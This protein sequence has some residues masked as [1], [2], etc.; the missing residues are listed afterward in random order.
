MA[1]KEVEA[2][3]VEMTAKCGKRIILGSVYKSP[4]TN[5]DK[6]KIH[7]EEICNKIK[8]EKQKKELVIGMDHNMDL[9]K[10]HE[11]RHTQ[12]F[13]DTLLNNDLIPTITRPTRITKTSATLI[14]N[15]FIS[16]MLQQSFDSMILIE[17]ISDHLPSLVLMKQTKLRNKDPLQFKSRKL[18]ADKIKC[19]KDD[20]K[21]KDWNGILRSDNVNTNFENFCNELDTTMEKFAL[22][23]EVRISWKRKH[24]E[25]WMSK[26]IERVAQRC[27][28]LY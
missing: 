5:D 11:H 13:L 12:Q 28:N 15:V 14:D 24:I 21:K 17:E 25:P 2:T 3:Y 26:S 10:S 19:L 4:N 7:L 27:K 22:I 9:L 16:K 8:Q 20:L 6:L 23:R 1:E 18:T